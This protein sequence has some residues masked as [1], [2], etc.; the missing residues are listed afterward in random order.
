MS[1]FLLRDKKVMK[2]FN[3]VI[4]FFLNAGSTKI[5]K[6]FTMIEIFSVTI[7]KIFVIYFNSS[8]FN[9]SRTGRN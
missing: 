3:I 6:L 4:T 1:K 7:Q 5:Q 8:H 2:I 9:Y